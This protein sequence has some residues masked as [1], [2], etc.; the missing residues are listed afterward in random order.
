MEDDEC[1]AEFRVK[2]Q[3]LDTLAEALQIPASFKCHQRSKID[4]VEAEFFQISLQ[5]FLYNCCFL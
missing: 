3:D 2:K 5:R 1:V 4:G